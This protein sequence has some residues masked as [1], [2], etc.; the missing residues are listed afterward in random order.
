MALDGTVGTLAGDGVNGMVD[1]NASQARFYFPE[2]VAVDAS[3]AVYVADHGKPSIRRLAA[4]AVRTLAGDGTAGFA[5]GAGAA[6]E[7]YG[8]EGLAVTPMGSRSS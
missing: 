2:A 1:G 8:E 3:G 5:D 4:G 7:F 6:A